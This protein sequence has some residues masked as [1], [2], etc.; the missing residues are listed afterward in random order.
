MLMYFFI[1]RRNKLFH[2]L[3]VTGIFLQDHKEDEPFLSK[4]IE[5]SE[6]MSTIH[7]GSM[8]TEQFA[9]G[10]ESNNVVYLY[11]VAATPDEVGQSQ[12]MGES[13]PLK[14][15]NVKTNPSADEGLQ[16]TLLTCSER[17][18]ISL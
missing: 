14:P 3:I 6:E 10:S 1:E 17:L 7:E 18:A 13:S 12:N 2:V 16:A 8:A 5:H 15:K 4:P 11:E 9:R